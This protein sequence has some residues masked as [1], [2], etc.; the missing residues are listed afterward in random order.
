MSLDQHFV[1]TSEA[2]L[3][4]LGFKDIKSFVKNQ[5]LLLMLAKID[6]YQTEDRLFENKY[7]VNF[8]EFEE[9]I[10]KLRNDEVFEQ[11]DD[12][13]DWRYA[14]ESLERLKKQKQAIENA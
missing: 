11:E 12:Y 13:L 10:K 3:A 8:E 5:A 7:K 4:Q 2:I 1:E 9:K 6:K 14:R